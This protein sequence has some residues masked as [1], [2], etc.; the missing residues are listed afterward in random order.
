MEITTGPIL[1]VLA[2]NLET[3]FGEAKRGSIQTIDLR[4]CNEPISNNENNGNNLHFTEILL[5]LLPKHG[6]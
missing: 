6:A 1:V 4:F 2:P 5:I 3:E